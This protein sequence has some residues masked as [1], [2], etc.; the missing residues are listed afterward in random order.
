MKTFKQ[1]AHGRIRMHKPVKYD[2][3]IRFATGQTLP[4]EAQAL[5]SIWANQLA[6]YQAE[7][8][9]NE[10]GDWIGPTGRTRP[11]NTIAYV[12]VWPEDFEPAI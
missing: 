9:R 3:S 10:D 8:H 7:A 4:I 12:E 11:K 1:D 5:N 6:D 2:V